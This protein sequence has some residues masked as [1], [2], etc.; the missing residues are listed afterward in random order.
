MSTKQQ[1]R[2]YLNS[3]DNIINFTLNSMLEFYCI[4]NRYNVF[5]KAILLVLLYC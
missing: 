2:K 5:Y 4:I 3:N 1:F